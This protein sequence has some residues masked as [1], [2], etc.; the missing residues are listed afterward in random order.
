MLS[1]IK[2]SASSAAPPPPKA[3]DDDEPLSPTGQVACSL[4]VF[5]S[6]LPPLKTSFASHRHNDSQENLASL[7][8]AYNA[9]FSR[10]PP[11]TTTPS[12][13]PPLF[14]PLSAT[15]A[16]SSR[17]GSLSPSPSPSASLSPSPTRSPSASPS[18]SPLL[19]SPLSKTTPNLRPFPAA[20]VRRS[21]T[22]TTGPASGSSSSGSRNV[23]AEINITSGSSSSGGSSGVIA[24]GNRGADSRKV[25]GA[26][27]AAGENQSGMQVRSRSFNGNVD[28][29]VSPLAASPVP[30]SPLSARFEPS[31]RNEFSR[32]NDSIG[33]ATGMYAHAHTF[34]SANP[35]L[36]SSGPRSASLERSPESYGVKSAVSNADMYA[37][38]PLAVASST[39]GRRP[40][41]RGMGG[42][43]S[44]SGRYAR[45]PSPQRAAPPAAPVEPLRLGPLIA[46]IGQADVAA[47]RDAVKAVRAAIKATP[48]NKK[49]LIQAGG[50]QFLINLVAESADGDTVEHAVTVMYNVCRE[51]GGR[52]AIVSGAEGGLEA[53]VKA[54]RAEKSAARENA[55]AALFCLAWGIQTV[56]SSGNGGGKGG[57]G[58]RGPS[59][60]RPT[61]GRSTSV[62][63][64]SMSPSVSSRSSPH[65]PSLPPSPALKSPT[66]STALLRPSY[67]SREFSGVLSG[68]GN[69]PSQPEGPGQAAGVSNA[70]SGAGE[71]A[72]GQA[73]AVT[74][75]EPAAATAREGATAGAADATEGLATDGSTEATAAPTSSTGA[76]DGAGTEQGKRE[77]TS[78]PVP[79]CSLS[80]HSPL[81]PT[82]LP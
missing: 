49:R 2:A 50:V 39:P 53:L 24:G 64:V 32:R 57:R 76:A 61:R 23:S 13:I 10:T 55:A 43:G 34:T 8:S 16:A 75:G 56:S 22:D 73:E 67:D 68:A 72:A 82:S 46:A 19:L 65:T 1:M 21:T 77:S 7:R 5:A 62:G 15:L 27:P 71:A 70:T 3:D 18:A 33:S 28:G 36:S 37:F 40:P 81:C 52:D 63:A 42:S 47:I 17:R 66:A 58:S 41:R 29:P 38:C 51:E 59:P 4:S 30:V 69:S 80:F 78:L 54:L 12:C 6:R 44:F 35:P 48:E 9:S 45:S 79:S 11:S 74:A 25:A 60:S 20:N 31:R 26:A 14:S